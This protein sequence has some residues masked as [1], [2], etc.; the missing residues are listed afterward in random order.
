MKHRLLFAIGAVLLLCCVL[1][2][3][4]RG[5][6]ASPGQEFSPG[7]FSRIREVTRQRIL[8]TALPD[9]SPQTIKALPRW[10][11]R[12]GSSRIRQIDVLPAG[13]DTTKANCNVPRVSCFLLCHRLL[14]YM[15]RRRRSEWCNCGCTAYRR[16]SWLRSWTTSGR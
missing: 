9:F 5:S 13:T 1:A 15:Y 4:S 2:W 11:R 7:D 3:F 16:T 12:F 10:F 8:R 6:A 14:R